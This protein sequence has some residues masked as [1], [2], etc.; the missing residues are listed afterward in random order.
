[1]WDPTD[2]AGYASEC[3]LPLINFTQSGPNEPKKCKAP[4]IIHPDFCTESLL[5]IQTVVGIDSSL[6]LTDVYADAYSILV[7]AQKL[8]SLPDGA[9]PLVH[10]VSYGSDEA[11]QES[12]AY[13]ESV[14]T[15]LM[16]LGARGASL[17]FASGDG[18]VEGRRGSQKRY[19]AGFPASSPYATSVGATDFVVKNV[20]GEEQAWAGSGGGFSY[21]FGRPAYQQA[22]V[23]S[24]LSAAGKAGSLPDAA[25]YNSTG[26]AFP[27]VAA[28]GGSQNKYCI[29]AMGPTGAYG[30]SAA[31]PVL[32]AIVAKLNA[33]RGA[34]GKPPL[35]FVNPLFYQH[36]EAFH[37]VT[38]GCNSGVPSMVAGAPSGEGGARAGGKGG[39]GACKGNVGFPAMTGWD[40]A[41]GL[42]TPDFAKLAAVAAAA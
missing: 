32:A 11:Q 13:M 34:A 27:D 23:A 14:N 26:R 38:L 16:K 17:L 8:Q 39:S 31:T 35:G 25:A 36:P 10:S 41:T 29:V 1:M 42:G 9:L 18:G 22:A 24:Y 21:E 20:V 6:P 12:P 2:M 15:A 5:D 40:A 33:R 3:H 37:D 7:W 4:I 30:T 28:L 19:A